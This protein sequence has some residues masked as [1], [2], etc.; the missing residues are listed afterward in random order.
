MPFP[1]TKR[2]ILLLV[3][4]AATLAVPAQRRMEPQAEQIAHRFLEA[5]DIHSP[6]LLRAALSP[7]QTEQVESLAA[8]RKNASGTEQ[9]HPAHTEGVPYYIFNDKEKGAFV[10]VSGDNRMR[11]VL[12]WSDKGVFGDGELPEGLADLLNLYERQ[13]A[14]AMQMEEAA[15]YADGLP[16]WADLEVKPLLS[17]QWGQGAP[18]NAKCPSAGRGTKPP[19]G[20]VAT[21]MAQI[22]KYYNY[23]LRGEGEHSY[24][25]KSKGFDCS[26]NYASASFGW[27]DMLDTYA[28]DSYTARQAEAVSELSYACGVAVDMDYDPSG[29]GAYSDDV[30]Y[31]LGRFFKC[32][33]NMPRYLRDYLPAEQFDSLLCAELANRR[34][35]L[36]CGARNDSTGHA[37]VIDGIDANHLYHFNWGWSGSRDGYYALDAQHPYTSMR[38]DYYH[39]AV[40]R[41]TPETTGPMEQLFY[42]DTFK[43]DR[44][45]IARTDTL[46][47]E[48]ST[49][50]CAN[51]NLSHVDNSVFWEGLFGVGLYDERGQF[52]CWADVPDELRTNYS[53]LYYCWY[54]IGFPADICRPG[55]RWSL[56]PCALPAGQEKPVPMHTLHALFDS[57]PVSITADSI[58]VGARAD[59]A[60]P[61]RQP[62]AKEAI[63]QNSARYDLQGRPL[64]EGK[65]GVAVTKGK[66]MLL[67]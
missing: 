30:P 43:V 24:V 5:N 15:S 40:C 8:R 26:F 62:V 61:V 35:I 11:D 60:T 20:C 65:R 51:A 33:P 2:A 48:I 52:I 56:R 17:T 10:I 59:D 9:P 42:A 50:V 21:A 45:A 57:I 27:E 7:V 3:M 34:P 32:N 12:G 18:Y 25:S 41:I 39:E 67:R 29:S 66:K 6:R 37:Y 19:A 44:Q 63:G 22:L 13:W 53:E 16:R 49:I 31:A 46:R 55:T 47:A 28:P 54:M 4:Q 1:T 58:F 23:P 64:G 38:Y 14:D 36:F